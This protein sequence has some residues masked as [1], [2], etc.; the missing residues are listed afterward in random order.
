MLTFSPDIPIVQGKFLFEFRWRLDNYENNI[1]QKIG[2][3]ELKFQ[4]N[5]P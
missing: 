4:A 2:I 5:H 1:D 3:H